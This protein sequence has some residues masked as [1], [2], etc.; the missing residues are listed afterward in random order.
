MIRIR[1]YFE[2]NFGWRVYRGKLTW[3]TRISELEWKWSYFFLFS[4]V[5]TLW[6]T[7]Y[8]KTEGFFTHP[9][10]YALYHYTHT[11]STL[12]IIPTLSERNARESDLNGETH[13]RN[14]LSNLWQTSI[15]LIKLG[16][17]CWQ[18][19]NLHKLKL[20]RP[21]QSGSQMTLF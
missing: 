7:R 1:T 12:C 16:R 13:G 17:E 19:N 5:S 10:H 15:S 21:I 11:F 4:N 14:F 6:T 2:W 9:L 18:T 20:D 3:R 8:L